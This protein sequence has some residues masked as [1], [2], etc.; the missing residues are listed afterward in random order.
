[1]LRGPGGGGGAHCPRP[2]VV[3]NLKTTQHVTVVQRC[4]LSASREILSSSRQYRENADVR[5]TDKG[6]ADGRCANNKRLV[7]G[8]TQDVTQAEAEAPAAF[9]FLF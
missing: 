7:R 2:F 6:S 3:W 4:I 8:M 1:M 5:G 9:C